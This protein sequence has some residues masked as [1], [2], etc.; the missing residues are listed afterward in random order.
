[1]ER[2]TDILLQS[3]QNLNGFLCAFINLSLP[4][5]SY[6]IRNRYLLE[7][8]LNYEFQIRGRSS[9]E[10]QMDNL[11]FVGKKNYLLKIKINIFCF[12]R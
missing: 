9:L 8:I 12:N 3:Y 4:S 6:F 5:Y 7:K 1:M 10:G 11:L 2:R